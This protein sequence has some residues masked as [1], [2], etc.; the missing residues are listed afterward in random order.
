MDLLANNALLWLGKCADGKT[1][2]F[3]LNLAADQSEDG[4]LR[5][6]AL[7]AYLRAADPE[8]AKDACIRFLAGE[9]R[10]IDRLSVYADS[11]TIYDETDPTNTNKRQAILAAL[12][13]AANRE[14]EKIGFMEADRVL[15][16]RS[17]AYRR[18]R[19]RLT[20]LERHSL[21]LPTAN[22]HTDRDLK[23]ALQEARRFKA[24]TSVST[25]LAALKHRDFSQALPNDDWASLV[26]PPPAAPADGTTPEDKPWPTGR[27]GRI[28]LGVTALVALA[29]AGV[30]VF[31]RRRGAS[32]P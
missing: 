25:N 29:A 16:K 13:V 28:A 9:S 2:A 30:W 23:A 22:V 24:R 14:E 10:N 6:V 3:L 18:S 26:I 1:K 4:V 19:E 21:E 15:S 11:E 17:D 12:L 5:T 20:M 31:R 27:T 32:R 8:E 7:F